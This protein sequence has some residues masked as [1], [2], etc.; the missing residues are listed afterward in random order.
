MSAPRDNGSAASDRHDNIVQCPHCGEIV[1]SDSSR[2]SELEHENRVLQTQAIAAGMSMCSS[3]GYINAGQAYMIAADR[4][5]E[6]EAQIGRLQASRQ[7]IQHS[8]KSSQESNG[9]DR[10]DI[11]PDSGT[12]PPRP[13]L[14]RFG[15]LLQSRRS[16]SNALQTSQ[17]Q[18]DLQNALARE[19]A[20]RQEAE[21]KV[22]EV[23]G[24]LEDLSQNLFEQANEMVASERR[25][26][27]KLEERVAILEQRDK[28]KSRRATSPPG[29]HDGG[30]KTYLP[31][32]TSPKAAPS[33][34][35]QATLVDK[36]L[37][38]LSSQFTDLQ[39]GQ[40]AFPFHDGCHNL[41]LKH[42]P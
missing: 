3:L 27:A 1:P 16:P 26:K 35:G 22:K 41:R 14:S 5:A 40:R 19:V 37:T 9:S 20:L 23:N 11:P 10:S 6:Y 33:A 28:E 25:A 31:H 18:G 42:A 2:V 30:R 38:A 15:S 12:E 24:E 21:K 32:R 29:Y 39:A 34:R 13:T 36:C 4:L 8:N 17:S 7:R